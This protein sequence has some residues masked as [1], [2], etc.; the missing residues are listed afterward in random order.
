[1]IASFL[2][3]CSW[4]VLAHRKITVARMHREEAGPTDRDSAH[5]VAICK[6]LIDDRHLSPSERV[7]ESAMNELVSV[8]HEVKSGQLKSPA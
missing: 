7:T 2:T 4:L 8:T 1:M 3:V 5:S 6:T